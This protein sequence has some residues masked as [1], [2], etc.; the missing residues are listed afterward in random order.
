LSLFEF[1]MVLVS[2]IVG[3]GVAEIL[4]GV[5]RQVRFRESRTGYWVHSCG[6]ALI[7][8]AL[9]QYWWELW[10][11]REVP[12]WSFLGLALM[13]ISPASLYLIAHLIF[14]EPARVGSLR[15]YYYESLGPV[16]WLAVLTTVASTLFRPIAFG[17]DIVDLDNASSFLL[18]LGFIALAISRN[19]ILHSVVV[20][21]FLI[22]LIWDVLFWNPSMTMGN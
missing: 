20:P 19:V 22:L 14:P 16:W 8:F 13:L 7:F 10:T 9:L 11:L 21:T 15:D 2:I 4:T 5:A 6:V 18:L 3:L 1:L 17:A 12:E